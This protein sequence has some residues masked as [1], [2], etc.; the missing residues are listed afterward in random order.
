TARGASLTRQLLAFG[1]KH[2]PQPVRVEVDKAVEGL[3]EMLRRLVR[4]DVK[5]TFD[6]GWEPAPVMMDPHDLE[7]VVLNLVMNARDALFAR[8]DIHLSVGRESN[9]VH[10]CVRD[11][12][13]GMT[14]ETQ[15][16][17][18]EPFFTTKGRGSGTG[19]GLAYVNEIAQ[20][21]GG[22]V[23]VA[24]APGEG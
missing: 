23:S 10:L 14:A 18:F 7:Q 24:S 19:V 20:R 8:G 15:A 1:G 4:E 3:R 5:L 12:G 11:N 2:D 9:Y 21:A 6:L 22:Y 13:V 17:L 16:H